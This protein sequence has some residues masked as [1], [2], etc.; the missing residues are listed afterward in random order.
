MKHLPV[1]KWT[2]TNNDPHIGHQI[3]MTLS[4]CQPELV[5]YECNPWVY[6]ISPARGSGIRTAGKNTPSQIRRVQLLLVMREERKGWVSEPCEWRRAGHPLSREETGLVWNEY[7]GNS[8]LRLQDTA[9]PC[10]L[11]GSLMQSHCASLRPGAKV[12]I[13]EEETGAEEVPEE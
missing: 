4:S 9:R 7:K 5:T 13:K 3:A 8:L 2:E 11:P 6:F 1:R 10:D 12:A